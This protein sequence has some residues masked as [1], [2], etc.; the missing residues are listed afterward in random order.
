MKRN[1]VI[2]EF[3]NDTNATHLLFVERKPVLND[4][5]RGYLRRTDRTALLWDTVQDLRKAFGLTP[6][7]AG[8]AIAEWVNETA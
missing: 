6:Q 7:D 1:Q 3:L 2:T 8:K 4:E 5:I